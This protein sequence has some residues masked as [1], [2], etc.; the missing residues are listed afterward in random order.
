MSV[1]ALI[2]ETKA[3]SVVILYTARKEHDTYPVDLS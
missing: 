2:F 3:Y 1:V